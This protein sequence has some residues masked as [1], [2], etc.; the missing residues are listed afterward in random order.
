MKSQR[1]PNKNI[2]IRISNLALMIKITRVVEQKLK[3]MDWQNNRMIE[4]MIIMGNLE[5]VAYLWVASTVYNA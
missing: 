3:P 5:H 1:M 2:Q 4:I